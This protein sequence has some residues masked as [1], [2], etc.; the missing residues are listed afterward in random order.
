MPTVLQRLRSLTASD[1]V[2]RR[3]LLAARTW[4]RERADDHVMHIGDADVR[5]FPAGGFDAATNLDDDQLLA[6]LE[7]IAV[8]RYQY[9]DFEGRAVR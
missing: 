1:P 2:R 8:A 3:R 6:L 7:L 4:A 9:M 5:L